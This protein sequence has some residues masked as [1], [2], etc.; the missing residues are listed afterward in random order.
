MSED[1]FI[2]AVEATGATDVWILSRPFDFGT[3]LGVGVSFMR[4]GKQHRSA[5]Q[6]P[7]TNSIIDAF[8][9]LLDWVTEPV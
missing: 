7:A 5:V 1:D 2:K 9:A 6:M 4:D 3:K 8:P